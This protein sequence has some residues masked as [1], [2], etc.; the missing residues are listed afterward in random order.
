MTVAAWMKERVVPRIQWGVCLWTA[1]TEWWRRAIRPGLPSA[2]STSPRVL[3]VATYAGTLQ[4]FLIPH[5]KM[6]LHRGWRV[7]AA[8]C[9][10]KGS[11]SERLIGT[12]VALHHVPFRKPAIAAGNLLALWRLWRLIQTRRYEI[13]HVHTPIAALIG[14]A[15]ARMSRSRPTVLYTAHGFHFHQGAPWSQWLLAYPA[16]WLA[17]RWTDGLI[18]MNEEDLYHGMK[19]GFTEG[20]NL[21]RVHGV[22]VDLGF[23]EGA[24][25]DDGQSVR[26]EFGLASNDV[27]VSCIAAFRPVKNHGL[28]LDAWKRLSDSQVNAHLLLVGGGGAS[29]HSVKRRLDIEDNP[30][31]HLGGHRSDIPSV[32]QATDVLVLAS[33]YEGLPRCI[34]E[35]MVVA[36]PVVATSARGSRDLIEHGSN[37]LLVDPEDSAGLAKALATLIQ[38]PDLR[39][40][41]GKHGRE[42]I[43]EYS[44]DCVLDEMGLIYDRFQPG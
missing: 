1:L 15:A 8:A 34:M 30:R 37:G 41:M 36:K 4:A 33:Q 28:L 14:R 11:E 23:Y 21:F 26:R 16:E 24:P 3:F 44:L 39:I 10:D 32:L 25:T 6:L 17:A 43:E 22:G 9:L 12:D 38:D 27:L 13:I 31:I 2:G 20:E 42:M 29:R 7:E 19:L 18:V 5:M 35:A 40:K